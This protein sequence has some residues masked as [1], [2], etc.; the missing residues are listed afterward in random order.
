MANRSQPTNH[1]RLKQRHAT[2]KDPDDFRM[3]TLYGIP[4]GSVL[5]DWPIGYDDLA[6]YYRKV[7]WDLGVAHGNDGIIGGGLIANDFVK[8]E[9]VLKQ[10]GPDLDVR[11]S[12]TRGG[13]RFR[14]DGDRLRGS[15]SGC[16]GEGEAIAIGERFGKVGEQDTAN[17]RFEHDGLASREWDLLHCRMA[18]WFQGRTVEV[19]EVSICRCRGP[20]DRRRFR[21]SCGN[22][23]ADEFV[24]S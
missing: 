23:R 21:Y 4:D 3:A 14:V 18:M 16:Q 7:E 13:R 9:R 5:A 20:F 10:S 24:S 1:Q 6:P 19:T 2:P 11:G 17:A 12:F 15:A 8:R 22:A